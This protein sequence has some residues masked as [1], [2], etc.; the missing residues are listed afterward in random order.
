MKILP[1]FSLRST[2]L[3]ATALSLSLASPAYADFYAS[4]DLQ[5]LST[6]ASDPG[7]ILLFGNMT[8]IRNFQMPVR[9]GAKGM[10]RSGRRPPR[11]PGAVH[12]C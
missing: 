4:D 3:A 9:L 2:L 6:Y 5:P 10:P 7:E 12:C 8:M 11:N 1:L